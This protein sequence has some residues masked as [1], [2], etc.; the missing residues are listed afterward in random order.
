MMECS[1]HPASDPGQETLSGHES[2]SKHSAPPASAC[3]PRPNWKR[4]LEESGKTPEKRTHSPRVHLNKAF[5]CLLH[6]TVLETSCPDLG[7]A[8]APCFIGTDSATR[9]PSASKAAPTLVTVHGY[10]CVV[11]QTHIV[12][13]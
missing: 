2:F 11:P 9:A 8:E 5:K 13:T 1:L 7:T 3:L 6:K 10:M 12:H 4:S